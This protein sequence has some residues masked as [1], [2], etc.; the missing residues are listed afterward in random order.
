MAKALVGYIGGF[1]PRRAR[2]TWQLRQRISDLETEVVRLKAEN[3]ALTAASRRSA[4]QAESEPP[5]RVL[6]H[7]VS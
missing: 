7:V 3:D 5:E 1:D 4:P 2:E 6:E